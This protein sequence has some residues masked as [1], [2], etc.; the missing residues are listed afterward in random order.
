[1]GFEPTIPVFEGTETVHA[2]DLEAT[3]IK[4]PTNYTVLRISQK[5]ELFI[6]TG[7]RTSVTTISLQFANPEDL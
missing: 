2:L 3:V 1:V 5:T 4:L 6:T 7:V